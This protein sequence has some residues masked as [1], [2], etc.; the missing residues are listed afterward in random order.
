[1]VAEIGKNTIR[2]IAVLAFL[3]WVC[4]LAKGDGV[5]ARG[6]WGLGKGG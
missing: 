5:L 4:F 3:F 6:F 2:M 1:M